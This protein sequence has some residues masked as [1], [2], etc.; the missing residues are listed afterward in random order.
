MQM[1]RRLG[2]AGRARRVEPER[3]VVLRRGGGLQALGLAGYQVLERHLAGARPARH[4]EAL[5]ERQLPPH[6]LDRRS[7]LLAHDR[8]RRAT[9]VQHVRVVARLEQR[10]GGNGDGPD[11]ERAPE[12]VHRSEEHTSELQSQSNIVCRLLL[13]KKKN[14]TWNG[15]SFGLRKPSLR[16]GG[17]APRMWSRL[18]REPGVRPQ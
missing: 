16:P 8:D 12:R 14:K 4:D 7:Q 2:R 13:E 18:A 10:I 1:N 9:V 15:G 5:E 11:L 17:P 3:D 6:L